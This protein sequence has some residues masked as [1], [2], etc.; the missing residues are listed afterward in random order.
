MP[1]ETRTTELVILA[2][3]EMASGLRSKP[4]LCEGEE[5]QIV[6]L[7]EVARLLE[8]PAMAEWFHEEM[9]EAVA[10]NV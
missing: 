6:I 9:G 10:R 3:R 4:N 2:C 5:N 1:V 7:E 8:I